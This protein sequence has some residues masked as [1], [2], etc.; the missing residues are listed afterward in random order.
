M[1]RFTLVELILV[2][3]IMCIIGVIVI[4][5]FLSTH[6]KVRI[7][8][9]KEDV[10]LMVEVLNSFK[11]DYGTYNLDKKGNSY[12]TEDYF[13]GFVAKLKK[14]NGKP[15]EDLP[16]TIN[17]K[18]FSYIGDDSTFTIK[19]VAHDSRGTVILG[20]KEKIKEIRK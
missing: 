12:T 19:I 17:F 4:P 1:K 2:V 15:Y 11:K 16:D 14:P 10:E 8:C 6:D 7:K 5:K 18:N 9:A 13:L 3:I 20:S